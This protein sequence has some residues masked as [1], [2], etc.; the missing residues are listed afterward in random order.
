MQ[1]LP[2]SPLKAPESE[3]NEPCHHPGNSIWPGNSTR[4]KRKGWG[5]TVSA[6]AQTGRS[7]RFGAKEN[8]FKVTLELASPQLSLGHLQ[9]NLSVD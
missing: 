7:R 3:N 1:L 8:K 9:M 5:P 4:G 6:P 2:S